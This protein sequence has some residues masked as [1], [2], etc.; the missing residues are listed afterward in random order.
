MRRRQNSEVSG[1]RTEMQW[2]HFNRMVE[3]LWPITDTGTIK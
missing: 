1:D 2:Q 3:V